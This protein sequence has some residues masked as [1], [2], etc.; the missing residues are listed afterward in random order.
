MKLVKPFLYEIIFFSFLLF[1]RYLIIVFYHQLQSFSRDGKSI[2]KIHTN[3]ELL[4]VSRSCGNKLTN[5]TLA[6]KFGVDCVIYSINDQLKT[7][8]TA[9][10]N[11]TIS[12]LFYFLFFL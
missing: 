10:F 6:L 8:H 4:S 2:K 11:G 1:F 12:F 9:S 3:Q 5:P 7:V